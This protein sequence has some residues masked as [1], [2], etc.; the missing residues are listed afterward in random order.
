MQKYLVLVP[1]DWPAQFYIRKAVYKTVYPEGKS[2]KPQNP[3]KEQK[4]L[5]T[6]K[7]TQYRYNPVIL[8]Q[9]QLGRRK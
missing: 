1:G 9:Q 8:Q 6:T 2:S 5:V 4:H 7:A 3:T